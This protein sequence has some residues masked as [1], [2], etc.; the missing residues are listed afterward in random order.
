MIEYWYYTGDD[1]YNDAISRGI[2]NQ[3]GPGHNFEPENQTKTEV[4][5]KKTA[6]TPC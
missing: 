1:S 5:N 4:R 3:Q 2:L 6:I